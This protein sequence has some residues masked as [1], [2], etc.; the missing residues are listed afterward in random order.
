MFLITGALFFWSLHLQNQKKDTNL[1]DKY[2][3][4]AAF[5]FGLATVAKLPNSLLLLPFLCYELYNRQ[6]KRV[7]LILLIF[8]IPVVVFYG[9]FYLET[10][11]KSFYGGNRLFYTHQ[12]PFNNGFDSINESGRPGFSVEE[13]RI[14]AL[15]S[16]DIVTKSPINLLYYFFGKF[17]GMIWYYPF[18]VFAL[19]S[20][21]LA[22]VYL[23]TQNDENKNL[24]SDI[25]DN[26]V[27]YL[28]LIGIVLN[29]LFYVI[30]IGNNYLGGQH[31]I[32]NRYFYIFPAFLFL[33]RKIDLKIIVPFIIIALFTV[34]PIISDPIS[35]SENPQKHTIEFPYTVFPIEYSQIINLPIW[36]QFSSSDYTI[37]DTDGQFNFEKKGII[38]NGTSHWLIK[39]NTKNQNLTFVMYAADESKKQVRIISESQV[40][41][42]FIDEG[43]VEKV[44]LL[45]TQPV[46]EE[47]EYQIY[48]TTIESSPDVFLIPLINTRKINSDILYLNGW[49]NDENWGNVSTK[50][51]SKNAT[52]MVLSDNNKNGSLNLRALSFQNPKKFSISSKDGV[53]ATYNISPNFIQIQVPLSIE[54]GVNIYR[55]SSSEGCEKPLDI[56]ELH[57]TDPRCLSVAIQNIT[58]K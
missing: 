32:G 48:A 21:I 30:I 7:L 24:I 15:I 23:K 2:L 49:Y 41:D 13:G 28:V 19:L 43:N 8:L 12:Y 20:F 40:T 51:I 46:Y 1:I 39:T 5:I 42:T 14:S 4:I 29:I 38:M 31:A 10:G 44:S 55:L 33:I 25:R 11:S 27:P 37:Y 53:I 22:I 58:I 18:T 3:I 6:I 57:S 35:V 52:F 17:T 34:I 45:L 9:F 16:T 47:A 50:W 54:K 36:K 56:P 26:P